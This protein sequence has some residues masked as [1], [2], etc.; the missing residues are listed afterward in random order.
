MT[1]RRFADFSCPSRGIQE[2]HEGPDSDRYKGYVRITYVN[3]LLYSLHKPRFCYTG[4]FTLFSNDCIL[5]VIATQDFLSHSRPVMS[6]KC[7][8]YM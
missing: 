1:T 6:D 8:E 3:Y 4:A 2:V 7:C 5:N